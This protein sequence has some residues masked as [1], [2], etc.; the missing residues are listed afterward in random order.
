M[1]ELC[2]RLGGIRIIRIPAGVHF[3][4]RFHCAPFIIF[5]IHFLLCDRFACCMKWHASWWQLR[6]GVG[7]GGKLSALGE[8]GAGR[9]WGD[10][11]KSPSLGA[12][13]VLGRFQ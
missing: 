1:C 4:I 5:E 9:Y 13:L 3:S 8:A 6:Q 11:G 12:C 7:E 10:G 2:G